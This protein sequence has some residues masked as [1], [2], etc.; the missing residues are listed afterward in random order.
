MIM[1]LE[2]DEALLTRAQARTGE[3]DL[4][5]LVDLALRQLLMIPPAALTNS[6]PD[7]ELQTMPIGEAQLVYPADGSPPYV[8]SRGV[9]VT[10]E[11]IARIRDEEGI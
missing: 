5:K 6:T 9:M 4:T 10:S 2:L 8:L 3:P 7:A 11:I 1:T